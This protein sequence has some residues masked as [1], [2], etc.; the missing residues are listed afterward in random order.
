MSAWKT[1]YVD[2]S[3]TKD[4]VIDDSILFMSKNPSHGLI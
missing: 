1:A 4:V 3:S 2:P